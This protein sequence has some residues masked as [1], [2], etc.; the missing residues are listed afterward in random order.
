MSDFIKLTTTSE[1]P[2]NNE[3]REF[4]LGD[5]AICV[6]NVNGQ[7]TAMDNVCLHRGGP[8]GQG[9]IEHGKV[10]CPWHGW[11]WD[12]VTG[13]A[14]HNSNAKVPVYPIKVEGDDVLIQL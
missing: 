8:I 2:A 12:P 14:A 13:E 9:V 7:I 10:I 11:G 5:K 6:A 3:A 1:L 4:T